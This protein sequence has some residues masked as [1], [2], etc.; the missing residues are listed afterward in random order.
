MVT[1]MSRA[2]DWAWPGRSGRSLNRGERM[3]TWV[4]LFG[5]LAVAWST[6]WPG[7]AVR[8]DVLHLTDGTKV[9]GDVKRSAE[10]WVVTDA[11][12][13][14]TTV[15][16]GKVQSIEL[17]GGVG[18]GAKPSPDVA[19]QRLYSLRRSVE[20]LTHVPDIIERY[21]RFIE[22]S[23]GT[24][25]AKAAE[26]ELAVWVD[27]QNRGLVKIGQQWV[28]PD[29]RAALLAQTF[30]IVSQARQ[31]IK[32]ARNKEAEALLVKAVQVDPAN[33]SIQYLRGVLKYRTN[34]IPA[35]RK[36]FEA[37]IEQITNH[38][39][40]LNNL[41]V[42]L[43]RQN[44]HA[45]SIGMYDRAMQA[46]PQDRQVLD[47]FAEGFNALPNEARKQPIVQKALK[48][49]LEQDEL[50]QRELADKG[51]FRWGSTWVDQRQLDELKIAEE[52]IK[53]RL[54]QLAAEFDAAQLRI[55]TIDQDIAANTQTMTR[56]QSQRYGRNSTGGL[57]TG[58]LPPR[59]YDLQADSAKLAE[60]R[61]Q[62]LQRM[63]Q[64]RA[65]AKEVEKQVPTPRYT[66]TQ[67]LIET[68]GT[69]IKIP[70]IVDAAG[71]TQPAGEGQ[72]TQ[73]ASPGGFDELFK[74]APAVPTTG[75][76]D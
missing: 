41:A 5:L 29:E 53:G 59:Y 71:A 11:K 9:E 42:I 3:R 10:G 17:K 1:A 44:A 48:R 26:K 13:T 7:G 36:A 52:K 66:G 57:T 75:A 27:R 62:Q 56:I 61:K 51:L 31:L 21:E 2:Y 63:Q 74:D 22:Q 23:K 49:F 18:A 38:A 28:T 70:G 24:E 64:I 15:P 37:V 25:T 69:P 14:V 54:D 4:R 73:P 35:A 43:S 68:E 40:S 60:E 76:A 72:A 16:A 19:E 67:K 30:A 32:D 55:N 6:S 39:P 58:E 12:G 47:N 46:S 65:A 50:L 20:N 8:A 34:E 45:A 33:P